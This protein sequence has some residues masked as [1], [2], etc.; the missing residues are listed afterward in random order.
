M[1]FKNQAEEDIFYMQRAIELAKEAVE[2]D[3]VPVGA[4]IVKDGE[5]IAEAF[6]EREVASMATA[7]AEILAI[8]ERNS[9]EICDETLAVSLSEGTLEFSKEWNINGEKVTISVEKTV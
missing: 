4:V 8:A 1:E 6:N 2:R 5:I 7:H 9:A 3:E